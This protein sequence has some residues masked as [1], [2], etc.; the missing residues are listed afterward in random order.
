MLGINVDLKYENNWNLTAHSSIMKK[1]VVCVFWYKGDGDMEL[2][3]FE[4]LFDTLSNAAENVYIFENDMEANYSKWSDN[5]VDYFALPEDYHTNIL[6]AWLERIHAD[7][8]QAYM[9]E[10]NAVFRGEKAKHRSQYRVKNRY[11]DYVWVECSGNVARGSD[12]A[13]K[14]FAGIITRLDNQSKYD[15]LTKKLAIHQFYLNN[16]VSEPSMVLLVGMDKFRRVIHS[17]GYEAGND[18]LITLAEKLDEPAL[19][20]SVYRMNG[21]EFLVV[22]PKASEK[23]AK[24]YFC[25]ILNEFQKSCVKK[26]YTKTITFSMAGEKVVPGTFDKETLMKRLEHTMEQAKTLGGGQFLLFSKE[27]EEKHRR[28]YEIGKAL[29]IAIANNYEGFEMY[30]QPVLTVADDKIRTVEALLRFHSQELGWVSPAEFIPILENAR[31]IRQVGLWVMEQVIRQNKEWNERYSNIKTSFNVSYLQLYNDSFIHQMM[32]FVREYHVD[33]N[34]VV[35]ELTESCKVL[36]PESLSSMF[37]ELIKCGFMVALDD[38]GMENSTLTILRDIP[39]TTVKIDHSFV[40]T[41]TGDGSQMDQANLAIIS[42]I[43]TMCKKLSYNIV[44][45]GVETQTV[46]EMMKG[47]GAEYL[48]GYYYSKPVPASEAEQFFEQRKT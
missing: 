3:K 26:N 40:R 44:V 30:Y 16:D 37:D 12:G 1:I 43:I 39:I 20:Q 15:P 24:K 41:I 46:A 11:G 29:E 25:D 19:N 48:Q 17:Y 8:R 9:D 13:L 34:L 7:D 18:L 38:F 21:D 23:S 45:E 33:P 28:V 6:D 35:V 4:L 22:L 32:E 5:A 36:H 10:I 2:E 14:L 27:I 42:G 31:A 47:L